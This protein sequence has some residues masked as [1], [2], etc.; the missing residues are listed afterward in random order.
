MEGSDGVRDIDS[1]AYLAKKKYQKT[2]Y[3]ST[4]NFIG[5]PASFTYL[6][7]YLA[8]ILVYISIHKE[9]FFLY[10]QYII[11]KLKIKKVV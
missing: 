2:I 1:V 3:V 5:M 8:Y 9:I 10:G 11:D 4:K 7:T 6:F